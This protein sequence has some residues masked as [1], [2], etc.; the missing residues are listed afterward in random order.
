MNSKAI[1]SI[2]VVFLSVLIALLSMMIITSIDRTSKEEVVYADDSELTAAE[3]QN[4]ELTASKSMPGWAI[5]LIVIFAVLACC[6]MC[7]YQFFFASNKWAII[8][9]EVINVFKRKARDGQAK[10]LTYKLKIEY[11]S[12]ENVFDTKQQALCCKNRND[13]NNN[14][15][16]S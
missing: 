8:D 5:A 1:N 4:E 10:L 12:L 15:E 6:G 3:T 14:E 9:G 16:K 11:V 7:Y 2:T 13:A